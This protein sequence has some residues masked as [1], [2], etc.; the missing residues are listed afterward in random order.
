MTEELNSIEELSQ[1]FV[2][3]KE[4]KIPREPVEGQK[5]ITIKVKPFGIEQSH[6][7]KDLNLNMSEEEAIIKLK[8]W[9]AESLGISIVTFGL[10]RFPSLSLS[11]CRGSIFF[12][13][14]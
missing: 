4:Y 7:F 8:P 6:L 9:I 5:Q 14:L 13:L 2:E 11:R 10:F 12:L 1:L 3:T